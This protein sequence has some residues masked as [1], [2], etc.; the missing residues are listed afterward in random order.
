MTSIHSLCPLNIP[1]PAV[2]DTSLTS[3]NPFLHLAAP[4][5][6]SSPFLTIN[7]TFV[8]LLLSSPIVGKL[9]KGAETPTTDP[10]ER[11][12]SRV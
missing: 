3:L 8:P 7:R 12:V 4:T 2:S 9:N 6:L 11:P 10:R 5:S 1:P